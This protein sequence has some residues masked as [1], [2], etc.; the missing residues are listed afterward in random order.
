MQETKMTR[1]NGREVSVLISDEKEA[2]LAAKAAGRAIIGLWRPEQD[3]DETS[4]ARYVVE[5][6]EDVT[7]EFLERVARRNMS[8]PWKICETERLVIREL[9]ADDF[10][11]V[12]SHEVGHGSGSVEELESSVKQQ[13]EFHEFGLWGVFE[14][15]S[16]NLAGV[17]G[18]NL[19]KF[20]EMGI[21]SKLQYFWLDMGND[22]EEMNE[23][24]TASERDEKSG[25]EDEEKREILEL[26]YHMFAEYRR[27]GY[28]R[29][30]CEGILKY[31]KEELG[32]TRYI[33]RIAPDNAISKHMA[34]QLGFK[35]G[36]I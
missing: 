32:V 9:F 14:K 36:D 8:L 13:Y 20:P 27:R 23:A 17:A 25:C 15:A 28:A 29:E 4:A 24:A 33:V 5:D 26:G 16:G 11:E 3:M 7:E 12:W 19:P 31:G 30:A 21:V 1:V 6:P 22:S 35:A 2:L 34:D 18:L 10:D